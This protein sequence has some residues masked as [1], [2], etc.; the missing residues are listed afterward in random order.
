M[1]YQ[2]PSV[3][4]GR[5]HGFL[6][7]FPSEKI[8]LLCGFAFC[9]CCHCGL[10]STLAHPPRVPC[11]GL[12]PQGAFSVK[13]REGLEISDHI[14]LGDTDQSQ[15]SSKTGGVSPGLLGHG[16]CLAARALIFTQSPGHPPTPSSGQALKSG[17]LGFHWP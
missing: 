7:R 5:G 2:S 4:Q 16:V 14:L 9:C 12:G 11:P 10:C 8:V 6:K 13:C 3:L 17:P 1:S 15:S